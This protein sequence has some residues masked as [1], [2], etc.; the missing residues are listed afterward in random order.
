M[1]ELYGQ[2]LVISPAAKLL[3]LKGPRRAPAKRSQVKVGAI[4]AVLEQW[5]SKG[6]ARK[7]V[8]ENGVRKVENTLDGG[9]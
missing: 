3:K 2:L 8:L 5:C 4:E 6:G 7:V 1:T 9:L